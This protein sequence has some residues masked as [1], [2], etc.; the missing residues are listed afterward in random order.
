VALDADLTRTPTAVGDERHVATG[1]EAWMLRRRIALRG[2]LSWSTVGEARLA[3]AAGGSV[4]LLRW[5]YVDGEATIGNDQARQGWGLGT[6][7]TF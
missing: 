2:G 7:V 4:A 5:L 6:R 3:F 1:A